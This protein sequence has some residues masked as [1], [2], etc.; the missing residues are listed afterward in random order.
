MIDVKKE[1]VLW[2]NLYSKKLTAAENRIL[3]Q[4]FAPATAQLERIK[5]YSTVNLC[6]DIAKMVQASIL[7]DPL[8]LTPN[9]S[10]VVNVSQKTVQKETT[11]ID[12]SII[13]IRN[14]T[15]STQKTLQRS[16][17]KNEDFGVLINDI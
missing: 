15:T 10:D 17:L 14:K 6:P 7:P 5:K 1:F 12:E 13:P 11:D 9:E 16:P 3:P 8:Q 4:N 2:E